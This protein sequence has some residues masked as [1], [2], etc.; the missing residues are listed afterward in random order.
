MLNCASPSVAPESPVS[1]KVTAPHSLLPVA[2]LCLPFQARMKQ[3]LSAGLGWK[4]AVKIIGKPDGR[5]LQKGSMLKSADIHGCYVSV[6]VIK[7]FGGSWFAAAAW[8][9]RILEALGSPLVL[10]VQWDTALQQQGVDG[11][12]VE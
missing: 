5:N 12:C 11:L 2:L 7:C 1:S 3:S 8:L 4:T 10:P 6:L 9:A